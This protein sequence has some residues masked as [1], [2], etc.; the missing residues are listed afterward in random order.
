ME[1]LDFIFQLGVVFAIYGFLWAIIELGFR[2]LTASRKRSL[3]EVY[4]IRGIKYVFLADVTFMF[5]Y[6]G[7]VNNKMNLNTQLIFGGIILLTYFVGKLQNNQNKNQMFKMVGGMMPKQENKLFDNRTEITVITIAIATFAVLNFYPKYAYNAISKWFVDS[8][9]D[10]ESTVIIGFI[11]K[12]VGFFFVVSLIAK[13]VN[14]ISLI[15][16]GGKPKRPQN[17]FDQGNSQ[18]DSGFDDYEEIS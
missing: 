2:I 10:I 15:L 4:I 18:D 12:I 9:V 1:L 16:N 3:A 6:Q 5:C 8:I 14:A 13:T 17:P 11:F 7:D